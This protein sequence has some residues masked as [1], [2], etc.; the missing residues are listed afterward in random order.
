[1]VESDEQRRRSDLRERAEFAA[2]SKVQAVT[3][4]T[5]RMLDVLARDHGMDATITRALLNLR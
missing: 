4:P 5:Q 3:A 2:F 1:M